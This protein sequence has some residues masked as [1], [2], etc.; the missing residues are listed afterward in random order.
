[1]PMLQRTDIPAQHRA[2]QNAYLLDASEAYFPR[3]S[4][5]STLS[6][7]TLL[8]SSLVVASNATAAS[9]IP[10]W[11]AKWPI[12]GAALACNLATTFYALRI[13][14][15]HNELIKNLSKK[16]DKEGEAEAE[17]NV[18]KL[19]EMQD[20]WIRGNYGESLTCSLVGDQPGFTCRRLKLT[21]PR[22]A[23]VRAVIMVSG[24]F[25]SMYALVS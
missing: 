23:L 24:A 2:R 1:M 4:I 9:L 8:V 16:M 22:W 17:K 14:V 11:A 21:I 13:M 6:N 20:W 25:I 7:A 12:Y 15:P 5:V 19:R 3:L 10:R 18:T